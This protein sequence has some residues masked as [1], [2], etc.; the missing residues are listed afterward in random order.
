[1]QLD[2]GKHLLFGTFH[3]PPAPSEIFPF[4][5]KASRYIQTIKDSNR[6]DLQLDQTSALSAIRSCD[7]QCYLCNCEELMAENLN[8]QKET[9][10]SFTQTVTDGVYYTDYYFHPSILH[11]SCS[12]SSSGRFSIFMSFMFVCTGKNT[13]KEPDNQS[14]NANTVPYLFYQIKSLCVWVRGNFWLISFSLQSALRSQPMVN[15]RI[16]VNWQRW[17]DA[18]SVENIRKSSVTNVSFTINAFICSVRLQAWKGDLWTK[19][20]VFIREPQA[21]SFTVKIWVLRTW[22]TVP[23]LWNRWQKR[24]QTLGILTYR[25]HIFKSWTLIWTKKKNSVMWSSY[26]GACA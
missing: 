9:E 1:M 15:M 5:G 4:I 20:W 14:Y 24:M 2:A 3:Q 13:L 16:H 21:A 19:A 22:M 18:D 23:I 10:A 25:K 26:V 7:E 12:S 6:V 8:D 17:R 11:I